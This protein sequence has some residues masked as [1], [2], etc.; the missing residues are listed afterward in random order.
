MTFDE[1]YTQIVTLDGRPCCL[2]S[3]LGYYYPSGKHR[4]ESKVFCFTGKL[5]CL[6]L[7]RVPVVS[8]CPVLPGYKNINSYW[9]LGKLKHVWLTALRGR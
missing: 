8:V 4:L 7:I 3:H 5:I 9:C 6:Q 2:F 1:H